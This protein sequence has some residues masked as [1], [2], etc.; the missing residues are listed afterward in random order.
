MF[1]NFIR[2]T[3][4]FLQLSL[5]LSYNFFSSSSRY[6]RIN[7]Q[8]ET[9]IMLHKQL[10]TFLWLAPTPPL[11]NQLHYLPLSSIARVRMMMK[12]RV[13][14]RSF[15]QSHLRTMRFWV[16]IMA[17]NYH[18]TLTTYYDWMHRIELETSSKHMRRNC[19]LRKFLSSIVYSSHSSSSST[20][21]VRHF[22]CFLNQDRISVNLETLTL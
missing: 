5:F 13:W 21:K 19:C 18:C 11:C 17:R 3:K 2:K 16:Q 12:E 20:E 1:I 8:F 9:F 22:I 6:I 14:L 15:L 10:H 4:S 7:V